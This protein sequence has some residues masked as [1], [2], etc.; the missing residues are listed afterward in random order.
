MASIKKEI[1]NN[2]LTKVLEENR[3]NEFIRTYF[4]VGEA[5]MLEIY[6]QLLNSIF[7]S[8]KNNEDIIREI[9]LLLKWE[10]GFL[11][12][13][14]FSVFRP[15]D[16]ELTEVLFKKL[17]FKINKLEDRWIV[18]LSES[19]FS[20]KNITSFFKWINNLIKDVENF[21]SAFFFK[22]IPIWQDVMDLVKR[23]VQ[24]EFIKENLSWEV[25]EKRKKYF[26]I[27][28]EKQITTK[29]NLKL[30]E[31]YKIKFS[32]KIKN[33]LDTPLQL[34]INRE[35]DIIGEQYIKKQLNHTYFNSS[36]TNIISDYSRKKGVF[37]K[38][39]AEKEKLSPQHI[40]H[41]EN[42]LKGIKQRI[43]WMKTIQSKLEEINKKEESYKIKGLEIIKR[44]KEKLFSGG[45]IGKNTFT[46]QVG[47]NLKQRI[48]ES[49]WQI[50]DFDK[51]ELDLGKVIGAINKGFILTKPKQSLPNLLVTTKKDTKN[52]KITLTKIDANKNIDTFVDKLLSSIKGDIKN[53]F[54]NHLTEEDIFSYYLINTEG[55]KISPSF[56][57][58][59]EVRL[60]ELWFFNTLADL[61]WKDDII[62]GIL[63]KK[64]YQYMDKNKLIN[65]Y[66]ID[67]EK[68]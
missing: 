56:Y 1:K 57:S 53:D 18:S 35:I 10:N 44:K 8:N 40:A 27:E 3:I 45:I 23:T 65:P 36:I 16:K 34:A 42:K 41:Y 63:D 31:K 15:S 12:D 62:Q 7:L 51:I 11:L 60:R 33:F 4:R 64:A 14:I 24:K 50:I 61:L 37:D 21:E 17:N 43:S 9:L 32:K 6:E 52:G 5:D 30:R 13:N 48:K 47:V 29:I 19:V 49:F 38:V 54:I 28:Y 55:K 66:D 25:T 59:L 22:E 68:K 2:L 39:L 46:K 20:N 26:L 67:K 58:K